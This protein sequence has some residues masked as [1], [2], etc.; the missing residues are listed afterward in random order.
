MGP[1]QKASWK[2]RYVRLCWKMGPLPPTAG[3]RLPGNIRPRSIVTWDLSERGDWWSRVVW[4]EWW[5][6]LRTG[7]WPEIGWW[8]MGWSSKCTQIC[9]IGTLKLHE[10]SI[11]IQGVYMKKNWGCLAETGEGPPF[12]LSFGLRKALLKEAWRFGIVGRG[13][14]YLAPTVQDSKIW[15]TGHVTSTIA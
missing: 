4:D 15:M 13:V 8:L 7:Q 1:A 9:H 14:V 3:L 12:A 11:E 6:S 5:G 10:T 2:N